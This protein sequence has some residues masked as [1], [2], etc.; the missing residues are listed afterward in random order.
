VYTPT[1]VTDKIINTHASKA[2]T[3]MIS[4]K[5]QIRHMCKSKSVTCAGPWQTT[6]IPARKPPIDQIKSIHASMQTHSRS[7]RSTNP[8]HSNRT[9]SIKQQTPKS[10]PKSPKCKANQQ[11]LATPIDPINQATNPQ[12]EAKVP[13]MQGKSITQSKG[14]SITHETRSPA[15]GGRQADLARPHS[16]GPPPQCHSAHA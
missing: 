3:V 14:L 15:C 6:T 5:V 4:D 8:R 10:K 2:S 16:L 11:P 9:Q 12:I 7:H 1:A 13:Q